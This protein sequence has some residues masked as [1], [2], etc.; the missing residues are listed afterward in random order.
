MKI[1]KL[2]IENV[3]SSAQDTEVAANTV[4]ELREDERWTLKGTIVVN[5]VIASNSTL[6]AEG[7]S[8]SH[9]GGGK[10]GGNA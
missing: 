6:I 3:F 10:T 2:F 1:I 7:D 8:V 4:G 5:D 9:T